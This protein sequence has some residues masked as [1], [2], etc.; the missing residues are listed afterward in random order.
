MPLARWT[1]S[2]AAW[3]LASVVV[4]AQAVGEPDPLF[5][6]NEILDVRIIAP[7]TMLRRERPDDEESPGRLQFTNDAGELIEFDIS[8]RTR[9]RFRL[10]KKICSFPPLRLNFK[11][12]QTKNT[13]FHGQDKVKLVTHCQGSSRYKMMVPREFLTYRI[14]NTLT[15]ISFR[16]RLMR[17]TYVDTDKK[18]DEDVRYGF[19]IEHRDRLAKGLDRPVLEIPKTRVSALN[20]EYLNLVSMYHYLIGNTDF[21]PVQG[22]KGDDC[23]HNH[24]LFGVEDQPILSVP[25]DFDQ[26]GI[27]NAPHAAPNPQFKSLRSV[28]ERLYRGRCVNNPIL[29]AT[30]AIYTD[31]QGDI[32]Q[33]INELEALDKKARKKV[34]AYVNKFYKTLESEKKIASEFVKKCI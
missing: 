16:V 24:V 10:Q 22:P 8:V 27:V 28:K 26:A 21:S 11:K 1:I 9:G 29:E 33:L 15:D 25:Y 19:S 14:L 13:L 17:V 32:L 30:I 2:A 23:C 34:T 7:L 6:S 18:N 5:R 12:S 20:P 31:R 4:Q 3:L